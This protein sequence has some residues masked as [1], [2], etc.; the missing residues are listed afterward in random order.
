LGNR[1]GEKVRNPSTDAD[2]LLAFYLHSLQRAA[3]E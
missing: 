1:D 2:P 3:E